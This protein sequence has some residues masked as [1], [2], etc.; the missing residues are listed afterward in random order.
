MVPL[1]DTSKLA[2]YSRISVL[3]GSTDDGS[4]VTVALPCLILRMSSHLGFGPD[5][6]CV[7]LLFVI[8]ISGSNCSYFWLWFMTLA[9]GIEDYE[10]LLLTITAFFFAP[11]S[12]EWNFFVSSDLSSTRSSKFAV[13]RSSFSSSV[14]SSDSSIYYAYYYL[15]VDF[16]YRS[17][18]GNYLLSI[19]ALSGLAAALWACL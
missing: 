11:T 15:C 5:V 19:M 14:L 2:L 12:T 16:F 4:A 7:S 1:F 3:F 18:R 6:I 9:L 13:L 8:E 17:S 10:N